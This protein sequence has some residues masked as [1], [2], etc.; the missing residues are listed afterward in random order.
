MGSCWKRSVS[1]SVTMQTTLGGASVNA[2]VDSLTTSWQRRAVAHVEA[3]ASWTMLP[4][5][6]HDWS[7]QGGVAAGA[8]D[9]V[10]DCVQTELGLYATEYIHT[11]AGSAARSGERLYHPSG[12]ALLAGGQLRLEV[13]LQPKGARADYPAVVY[14]WFVDASNYARID[15]TTG[16]LTVAIGGATNTTSALTW[17]AAD[18]LELW[19]AAGGGAATVV[20]FRV[21]GG[22]V[23]TCTITGSALGALAVPG[24]LD[25]LCSGTG[26]QFTAWVRALRAYRAAATPGWAV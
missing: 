24:A 10:V 7:A 6:G 18:L 1:G 21:N 13:A 25:L 15:P 22:A 16:V 23:T 11:T 14:L 20:K 5:D 3:S 12:A 8:R 26:N 4:T 17:A 19:V 2:V 9:E